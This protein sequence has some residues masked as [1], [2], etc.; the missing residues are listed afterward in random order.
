MEHDKE[1]DEHE[2]ANEDDE[3][4]MKKH[5]EVV[6]DD[7]EI[8]IDAIP[9]ATKPP[10][11]NISR[12][13]LETLWKLVKT[14]HGN[15]RPED[16]Y[17]KVFWGDLKVMFEPDIKSE[18]WRSLQGYKVIVW[19]LFDS[20]GVH[21]V[22]FKYLH[23]FM[24]VEK[25]FKLIIGMRCAINYSSS[26]T[27]GTKVNVA[28][29]QLLEELLL[30]EG[31]RRNSD[32]SSNT[33]ISVK[34]TGTENYRVWAAAMKLAIN[35][36]NKTGFIDGSYIKSAYA[37]SAPCLI[38]GRDVWV[39]LKETYDKLDRSI[40]FNLLQKN[41]G[42]KQA[43][44]DVLKHNQLMKLM[45]F[46]M[47]LNEVFQPIKS[48]LLSREALP[49]V[50]DNFAIISREESH[51]GIASS[52]SGSVR[53]TIDRCFDLIGY[54]PGYNKN[55]GPK[56]NGSKTFNANS[57]STSNENG[58]TLSFTNEQIIKLMNLI[59]EVPSIGHPNGTLAKIK[60]V[61]N[62]RLSKNVVLFDVL[63]VLEYCDLH[64]N[65]IMGTGNENGSLY[66]SDSPSPIS[67]NF[68]TIGNQTATCY[69]SK[70][71]WHNMLG[72]PSDQAKQ[73]R[74]PFP[75]SDHKTTAIAELV[76]VDLS[77]TLKNCDNN[78]NNLNFFDEKHSHN[79]T[80]LS[81]NDDGRVNFA[82]NDKGNVYP[83]TRSTQTSDGSEDNIATSMGENTSS[84]GI[85]PSS[86]ALID[87]GFVQSK[88][89][90]SLFTKRSGDV[91]VALLMYVDD[92]VITGN[93]ISE[94]EKFK[95]FLKSK[96]QIKDLGK[97]KY[98]LGIEVLDNADGICLSQ[99]KYYLELL[100]EQGLLAAK[101]V[102]T[103][104]DI[105]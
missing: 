51:R 58:A 14:K 11:I 74:E 35:T 49:D 29:L 52:S 54:P 88:F 84:K 56:Q 76:H 26:C 41:Y 86:S 83:C 80:F 63:V 34:L 27:A 78:I 40:I 61:G 47:G 87:N 92:I 89:D 55:H 66:L 7:E 17:E 38:S 37:N 1:T 98:F 31:L 68:Q 85:V 64:H 10:I 16:D 6:Q 30:S 104:D 33:I 65:K 50:K 23:I 105:K 82:P 100:Y 75:L 97:L 62:L 8:A 60:H 79:Q 71:L 15:T 36:R 46:L 4:E 12:E 91:F 77:Q 67:P 90:Y 48:S 22:R 28:G 2:E 95:V 102:D 59:N 13:D 43:R 57:T 21:F 73:T 25:N 32:F 96:F 44:E 20:S 94:I 9:L 5:M 18:I 53:H 81:P 42:F 72:H 19:K 69:V 70:S 39:K 93:N 101:H 3:A 45:Q 103:P 24:L 99:R